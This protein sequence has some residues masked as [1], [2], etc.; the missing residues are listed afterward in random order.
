MIFTDRTITVKKGVSSINDTIILYRG[1]KDIEIRFTLN[2]SSPFKFGSGSSSNI[3]EK[4]EAAYGQLIIKTPNDL[5]SIF[6]EVVPTNE[7][8]IIFTITAEIIDEIT[9]VG[10]YTFQIRLFDEGMNSRATLPEVNNGIEIRE[11]IATED[12]TTTNEVNVATVGY[13][14]T[15][16][17]TSE[18][19]FDSEGNYNKTTWR[20]GDRIT[21][22]KLNK[23]ET[24]I[25][26]INKKANNIPTRTSQLENDSDYA[27]I[28][29][30]NQ[31]IDNAQLGG[32][33]S[34]IN[35]T[36][37]SANT[38]Y[39]SNKIESIKEDL[40]SQINEIENIGLTQELSGKFQSTSLKDILVEIYNKIYNIEAT[41]NPLAVTIGDMIP[42]I[43]FTS[44]NWDTMRKD[45]P[46]I[47]SSKVTFGKLVCNGYVEIK[48][49]GNSS[50]N[51]PKKNYT[52]K[53]YEDEG[54]VT[55]QK[56]DIKMNSSSRS[57]GNQTKFCLKANY[58]DKTHAR[59]VVSARIASKMIKTRSDFNTLPEKMKNAPNYG[60]IDGFPIEIYLN[61]E[62]LGLYTWNI[63]KD[64]WMFGMTEKDLSEIVFCSE[65]PTDYC[66]Y[67]AEPNHTHWSEEYPD[68]SMGVDGALD[69][70]KT[71]V[72]FV[73][74]SD[75]ETFA[76]QLSQH[77]NINSLLDY[78]IFCYLCCD[79]DGLGKN[80]LVCSYDG[81][82]TWFYSLYDLD[83][84]F[85]LYWNGG[86]LVSSNYRC[87]EDYET[88]AT[89]KENGEYNLLFQRLCQLFPNELYARYIELRQGVLSNENI[90]AEFT[91]FKNHLP[92]EYYTRDAERWTE[93]P[94]KN[95]TSFDQITSFI[96]E[97]CTYVDNMFETL[98]NS[99][100]VDVSS[101]TIT[102][103]P[104]V[105]VGGTVQLSA[106]VYPVNAS[107]KNVTWSSNN[108]T[109]ATVNQNGLVTTLG[110]GEV[111]ITA[112]SVSN[113]N[114]SATYT[115]AITEAVTDADRLV[116]SG[117][118]SR[119]IFKNTPSTVE[120]NTGTQSIAF[121]DTVSDSGD[122]VFT[123]DSSETLDINAI[124]NKRLTANG[125]TLSAGMENSGSGKI[126]NDTNFNK[127]EF[128]LEFCIKLAS[129]ITSNTKLLVKFPYISDVNLYSVGNIG[130]TVGG[131]WYEKANRLS[132]H[133][134]EDVTTISFVISPTK[135]E[136][137]VDGTS[138][139]QNT[140][141]I[142]STSEVGS[143]L[144]GYANNFYTFREIRYYNKA[145]TAPEL[146]NNVLYTKDKYKT[147]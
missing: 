18:D 4:T 50:L 133:V 144:L 113:I 34:N 76:S 31:A 101:I 77:F 83:S 37:A 57:W 8:K 130:G 30:V 27:T 109:I 15:T 122:I 67:R 9:E 110:A 81:G 92:D 22:A 19:A 105:E 48:W 111:I 141:S 88:Y 116:T 131:S 39:S 5:P 52:V 97:R 33:G 102:G 120:I 142:T 49:Q 44:D 73:M 147:V 89:N 80:Q 99:T 95:I 124:A 90:I 6:S 96:G 86:S 69:K 117:L 24:G 41:T 140:V 107:N 60:L 100:T 16:A 26:S 17:G 10:N 94:S 135:V 119:W 40:S 63:P 98:F 145:L 123:K 127:T 79:I 43:D 126:V 62:Y 3:I 108:D 128:T 103:N 1:D 42:R 29:Q 129:S 56:I 139:G 136:V 20:T 61:N 66:L 68:D 11:P 71:A 47:A 125:F 58:I 65:V 53:F 23:I 138:L 12:I 32:G 2:E 143:C 64:G 93:I 104:S 115:I 121:M 134:G 85:G 137:F 87:P 146:N 91:A 78:Y 46:I 45:N 70:W 36:T 28:T 106:V 114:I 25:D 84:T 21:A 55:K 38:T 13:A 112:T 35:D 14:L 132:E 75:D 82:N 74:S 51:Y 72:N 59:N 118:Q 54:K 7:G